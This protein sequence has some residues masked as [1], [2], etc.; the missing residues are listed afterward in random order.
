MLRTSSLDSHTQRNFISDS[1]THDKWLLQTR[2]KLPP[3]ASGMEGRISWGKKIQFAVKYHSQM[4][5]F[6]PTIQV[7][8]VANVKV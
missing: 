8:Q 6:I 5:S 2:S 1:V 7:I 4:A 3:L